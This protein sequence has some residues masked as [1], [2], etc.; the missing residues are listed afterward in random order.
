[1]ENAK[2]IASNTIS[3]IVSRLFNA[4]LSVV[5]IKIITHYLRAGG[6]GEYT[7][8][9]E[10]VGF[11]GI[12]CDLG[13]FTLAVDEMSKKKDEMGQIL[14][15]MLGL[16]ILLIS[17]IGGITCL[18]AF[19]IPSFTPLMSWSVV[20]ATI[21]LAAYLLGST[22]SAALQVHLKMPQFALAVI[23]GKTLSVIYIAFAAW[24][25]W[26]F[27]HLIIAGL[28]NNIYVCGMSWLAAHKIMPIR[29]LFDKAEM[30]RILKKSAIYGT[31][32]ILGTIYLRINSLI[33][34]EIQNKETVG[35][36][37][38]AL[39]SY[40]LLLLIPFSFMN[41]VLP[42]LSAAH[43]DKSRFDH[44][45]QKSWDILIIVGLGM[46]IGSFIMAESMIQLISTGND[47][48]G[49]TNL[50][51]VLVLASGF[52]F[53]SSLF[54]YI[55]V[56]L[57]Q[58]RSFWL[59]TLIEALSAITFALVFT[60]TLSAYATAWA[61]VLA[62]AIHFIGLFIAARTQRTFKLSYRTTIATL[63]SG[64]ICALYLYLISAWLLS[65]SPFLS[66]P[67]GFGT[68]GLLYI[69]LLT[70]TGGLSADL[71]SVM[72]QRLRPKKDTNFLQ[73]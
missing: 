32:L 60:G 14:G 22:I 61:I 19:F 70:K 66:L 5:I 56:S 72:K 35:I 71:W 59:V 16:R 39:R 21:G 9:Y 1:M 17:I 8:V 33:L 48:A 55:L 41:S 63:I 10:L 24:F 31:A 6:Y 34:G 67:F 52:N 37:G 28:I 43:N 12:A 18:G 3:Q 30:H 58:F 42:S 11:F 64:F 15:N 2:K 62:Q 29:V 23:V 40:E 51:R 38:V 4:V 26:G 73:S 54:Q 57:N 65:L 7:L 27:L 25:D 20:I 53:L 45:L 46:G 44:L 68:A 50:M 13:L 36:F 47:F 69:F 49:S